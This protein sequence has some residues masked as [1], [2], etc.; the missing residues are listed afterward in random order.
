[1]CVGFERAEI[2]ARLPLST[3]TSNRKR[4]RQEGMKS[5]M[6]DDDFDREKKGAIGRIS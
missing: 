2:R 3:I 4:N 1:M 6:K 5:A